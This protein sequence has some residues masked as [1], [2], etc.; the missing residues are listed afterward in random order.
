MSEREI[1][2]SAN[3]KASAVRS[4]SPWWHLMN[5]LDDHTVDRRAAADLDAG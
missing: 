2:R 3:T 4:L 5:T 1:Q